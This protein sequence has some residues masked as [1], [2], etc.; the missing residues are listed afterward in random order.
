MP[1]QSNGAAN[2]NSIFAGILIAKCSATT[3]LLAY[4]PCVIPV[5]DEASGGTILKS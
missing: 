2:C 3:I 4:P 5:G 1:A